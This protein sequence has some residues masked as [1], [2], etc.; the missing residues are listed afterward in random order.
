MSPSRRF[1]KLPDLR[2]LRLVANGSIAPTVNRQ[3]PPQPGRQQQG[4]LVGHMVTVAPKREN[5]GG[6]VMASQEL[7]KRFRKLKTVAK[8]YVSPTTMDR[9]IGRGELQTKRES[10]GSRF[11]VWVAL[12]KEKTD[13]FGASTADSGGEQPGGEEPLATDR[14]EVEEL[15]RRRLQVK[16]LDGLASYQGKLLN[17]AGR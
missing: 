13:S 12:P 1:K 8:R 6:E 10:R 14:P 4:A 17:E 11:K 3:N 16:N 2:F 15:I 5:Q 9:M 7:T